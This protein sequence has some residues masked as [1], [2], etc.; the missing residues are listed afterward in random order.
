[1]DDLKSR[2]RGMDGDSMSIETLDE[3]AD[4]IE[5]LELALTQSRAETAAAYE[6]AADV[7]FYPTYKAVTT[8]DWVSA[9]KAAAIRALAT[10]D[11]SAALAAMLAEAR[12]QG[13]R[14]AAEIAGNLLIF[15][16]VIPDED[17]KATYS[18]FVD[19]AILAAI[20][21]AKA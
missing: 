19:D 1:M 16:T 15:A 8:S 20:K 4:R 9:R 21:G 10:S 17:T 2:L 18:E 5:A 6:R 3:A 7:C 14:E 13:M 12:A 11:Q